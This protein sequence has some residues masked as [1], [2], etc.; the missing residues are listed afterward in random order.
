MDADFAVQAQT[1]KALAQRNRTVRNLVLLAGVLLG[2]AAGAVW[3]GLD[4]EPGLKPQDKLAIGLVC[5]MV[6]AGVLSMRS[7]SLFRSLARCPA[8]GYNWEIKEGRY[9]QA[10]EQMPNWSK[11]PGC[12]AAMSDEAL[13]R[14]APA[15]K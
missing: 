14:A 11:C 9:V 4:P 5:G 1:Q 10:H 3:V 6:A 13:R 15:D 12:G 8:C 2:V 7:R